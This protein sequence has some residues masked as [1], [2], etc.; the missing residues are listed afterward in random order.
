MTRV[1]HDASTRVNLASPLNRLAGMIALI[2]PPAERLWP[3]SRNHRNGS[4]RIGPG[5]MAQLRAGPPTPKG[6]LTLIGK[7][8]NRPN[9]A[10]AFSLAEGQ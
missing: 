7:H 1:K 2:A 9:K 8:P 3:I 5:T 6:L 10:A 4:V